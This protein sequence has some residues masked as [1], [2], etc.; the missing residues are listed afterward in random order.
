MG[1][2]PLARQRW[3]R[4]LDPPAPVA[5]AAAA[6]VLA[7]G[8]GCGAVRYAIRADASDVCH[9]HCRLCQRSSGAPVVTWLTVPRQ[10]LSWVAGAP[11]ERRSSPHAVR[12]FCAD[13][14][15]A[16]TFRADT[17]PDRVD[18][19]VASLDEPA[20]VTPR[21]H[22]WMSSALPWLRLDDDL[23]RHEQAAERED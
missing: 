13:C 10:A 1:F 15:A 6:A 19:T 7:G 9:C 2:H 21:R 12:G 17:Q 14:G 16:L 11:R 20:A 23:P 22:I 4:R 18:V 8:C 5:S 3:V